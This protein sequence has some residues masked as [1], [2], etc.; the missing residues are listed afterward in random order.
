MVLDNIV[1]QGDLSTPEG[2]S[3]VVGE[4]GQVLKQIS[5]QVTRWLYLERVA[6]R[7]ELPPQ[8]AAAQLGLPLPSQASRVRVQP[9]QVRQSGNICFNDERCLLELALASPRAARE[10]CDQGALQ[11]L[12]DPGLGAVA[13][14]MRRVLERGGEPNPASVMDSLE[15]ASLAGLV[16]QLADA[17]PSLAPESLSKQVQYHL[18]GRARKKAQDELR[19]INQAIKAADPEKDME[20]VSRLQARRREIQINHLRPQTEEE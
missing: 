5:D 10:L 18:Q 16:I 20:L 19:A 12:E 4:A 7:L 8:V 13:A 11:G 6:G 2:K 3:R 15:D 1:E 17:A 14:A 9:A